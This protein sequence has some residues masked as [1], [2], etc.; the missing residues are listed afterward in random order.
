MKVLPFIQRFV[1]TRIMEMRIHPTARI[2]SS[3]LIDRTWPRGINIGAN[4]YVGHEAVILTHD[5]TRGIYMDTTI[6]S[7]TQI[8]PRAIIFP[9]VTIGENCIVHPGALVNRD[10]PANMQAIGNPARFDPRTEADR[11]DQ[12]CNRAT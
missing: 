6:G 11:N 2:E 9:G 7:G 1:R 10:M 4:C 8:G 5:M 3:A 12:E